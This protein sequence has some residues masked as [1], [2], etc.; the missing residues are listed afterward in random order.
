MTSMTV[1]NMNKYFQEFIEQNIKTKN[2]QEKLIA[3]WHDKSTQKDITNILKKSEKKNKKNKDPNKPKRNKT[4]YIFYCMDMRDAVKEDMGED[5]KSTEVTKELGAR[6]KNV[7]DKKKYEKLATQ[8]K[9][10]Y[11]SEMKDYD[12][13]SDC[14]NDSKKIKKNKDPNK[15]KRNKTAY[16]FYCMDMR[17]AVKEDMGENTKSTEVTKELGARWRKLNDK[18]KYEKLATQDKERYNSEMKEYDPPSD[19]SSKD[20]EENEENED[21]EDDEEDEDNEYE[22]DEENEDE[23]EEDDE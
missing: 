16:I 20:E 21:D 5:T 9:E 17:D 22:N 8:D 6:W 15:P 7:N 19:C 14:S 4:A 12:P 10:R 1:T 13:P 23:D 2:V 18:K 3:A 11:N